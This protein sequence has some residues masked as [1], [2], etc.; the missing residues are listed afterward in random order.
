M[1]GD[2]TRKAASRSGPKEQKVDGMVALKYKECSVLNAKEY[3]PK[4]L[5]NFC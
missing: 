2:A 4:I 5:N 3:S 1:W